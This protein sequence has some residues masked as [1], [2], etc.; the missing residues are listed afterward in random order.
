MTPG[1]LSTEERTEYAW[2]RICSLSHRR[3][4]IRASWGQI[5]TGTG[6]ATREFSRE[7]AMGHFS[8][9]LSHRSVRAA[10]NPL[11]CCALPLR[12]SGTFPDSVPEY[13][14]REAMATQSRAFT[15][16]FGEDGREVVQSRYSPSPLQ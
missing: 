7:S 8:C 14:P 1:W 6:L 16:A 5:G 10:G 4:P 12:G 2:D 3:R 13:T 15:Q 11:I 9:E